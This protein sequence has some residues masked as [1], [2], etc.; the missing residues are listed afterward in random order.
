M[1]SPNT[2]SSPNH[3]S[4][5]V[6]NGTTVR[7]PTAAELQDRQEI[8]TKA[9]AIFGEIQEIELI[10]GDKK[11]M[12]Q[13]IQ[14]ARNGLDAPYPHKVIV[15]PIGGATGL[16]AIVGDL[17]HRE[18]LNE[19]LDL[20]PWLF[21][22]AWTIWR[23]WQMIWVRIHDDAPVTGGFPGLMWL[24]EAGFLPVANL[25]EPEDLKKQS[26]Y[27]PLPC[28]GKAILTV[29]FSDLKWPA[30]VRNYFIRLKVQADHG[31]IFEIN[32]E[33]RPVFN[34]VPVA[35][36][37]GEALGLKYSRSGNTFT[38][39][40]D[41]K[42]ELLPKS[43]LHGQIADSLQRLAA[44]RG[45]PYNSDAPVDLVIRELKRLCLVEHIDEAEGLVMFLEERVEL[46][47]GGSV[48]AQELLAA[49]Q[50]FAQTRGVDCFPAKVFFKKV[51][52]AIRLKF[53]V[54]RSNSIKR[55][56][57]NGKE[58]AKTGYRGIQIVGAVGTMGGLGTVGGF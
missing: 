44:D 8:V 47:S 16:C 54:S 10:P 38:T 37:F 34:P 11:P 28:A 27:L 49:Y 57:V 33:N 9:K 1:N 19:V 29:P 22:S 6:V 45:I 15:T 23:Q 43:K 25:G 58:I 52:K 35:H 41:E 39:A 12:G 24:S 4:Y 36:F 14:A 48:T 56:D 13:F 5:K 32:P 40:V 26:E 3:V 18:L 7:I 46:A 30:P 42:V 20:N 21:Q 55:Q 50:E 2:P 31:P 51:A 53:H 17:D